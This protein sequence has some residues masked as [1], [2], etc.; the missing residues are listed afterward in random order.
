MKKSNLKYYQKINFKQVPRL[1]FWETT[2]E[3]NLECIHC[4][5]LNT[6]K[7]LS[8][9]DL[10][11]QEGYTFIDS[12]QQLNP[13]T[14]LVFSGGEPLY[15]RDIFELANYAV[16]KNLTVALATNGT[17]IDQDIAQKILQSGI[18]R[19]SVSIDGASPEVHDSFR[20]VKGSYDRAL[21]GIKILKTSGI[22]SQINF[23]LAKHNIHQLEDIY[24]LALDLKLDALHFFML[25]PVGCGVEISES[26]LLSPDKYEE[27][28][29]WIYEKSKEQKIQIKTTCAPHYYRVIRQRAKQEGVVITPKTHGMSAMTK[30]CL[31]G[32]G[33]CF[34]S[35]EGEVFPCGYFPLSSGNIRK[36]NLS[37]I[38]YKSEIFN[39]LRDPN[40]LEGKCGI[41]EYKNV[42]GGCRARA[43]FKT[44][45]YLSEEPYCSYNEFSQKTKNTFF[46]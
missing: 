41:C 40:K 12:I 7:E 46:N 24:N 22:S 42:C 38:W 35:H 26:Q 18:H 16:Q 36:N 25:V 1:I 31:A 13:S 28:L 20:Q 30:G 11:T 27:I 43:Y 33:V 6:S 39:Q 5:R 19:V 37:S 29:N 17:L 45:N 23:T 15:R 14:I 21:N 2:T 4:R 44:G 10:T 8:K 34:I 32:T 3:C 9:K